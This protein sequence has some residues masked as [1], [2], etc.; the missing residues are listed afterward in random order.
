MLLTAY[1]VSVLVGLGLSFISAA[2]I[3]KKLKR[4][5]I[6]YKKN[7]VS[8]IENIS[9]LIKIL[10]SYAVPGLN[11]IYGIAFIKKQDELYEHIKNKAISEND[12]KKATA[13]ENKQ[14]QKK[15]NEDDFLL[16]ITKNMKLVAFSKYEGYESDLQALYS[17]A[18][19][20]FEIKK[21]IG[22]TKCNDVL[23]QFPG[24]N[25]ILVEIESRINV[26]VEKQEVQA[27]DNAT[28]EQIR[29]FLNGIGIS[30]NMSYEEL[31]SLAS[32]KEINLSLPG[33]DFPKL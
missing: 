19:K 20:Y 14:N 28:L 18:I 16:Y 27:Q 29:S 22:A 25:R 23:M 30:D 24:F 21:K 9:E 31:L 5:G 2:S 4:E 13:L 15:D 7:K 17:L 3:V 11:I 12:L 8:F 10:L 6:P 33:E 1:L 32:I 26:Y